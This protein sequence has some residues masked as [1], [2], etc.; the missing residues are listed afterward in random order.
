MPHEDSVSRTPQEVVEAPLPTDSL[1]WLLRQRVTI[2]E[3]VTGYVDRPELVERAMPTRRRLTVLHASAGFGKTT[4]LAECCRRLRQDGVATAWLSLDEGDVPPVLDAYIALACIGAGLNLLDAPDPDKAPAGPEGRIGLV[5]R[6]IQAFGKP[7][8]MAFDELERLRHPGSVSLL[9]FLLERGPSNLHLAFAC[10]EIPDGLDVAGALLAGR[11]EALETEDLRFSRAE[12]AT[13]FDLRLSRQ[14]LAEEMERST[15]WPFALRIS[16]NRRERAA[17]EAGPGEGLV[18]NWM[19]SRLLSDLGRD[20]REFVLDLGLFGWI[21][22]ALL[23]E[24]LPG[25]DATRRLESLGVLDGLLEPVGGGAT[26]TWRLH[27]LVREHCAARR[28]REDPER[29]SAIHRRIALALAGR[30]ETVLAMRHANDGGDPSLAGE[31]LERAGGVRVWIRQGVVQFQEAN[32]LLTREAVS[33]RPR[34]RRARCAALTLSGRHHEA[35]ALYRESPRPV[36]QA[37]AGDADLEC[38]L[39]DCIVRGA[40]SL[41]GGERIGSDRIRDLFGEMAGLA[42]LPSL[43]AFTRGYF[44]YALCILHSLKAEFDQ[45]LQRLSAARELL[46][47]THYLPLYGELLQGQMEFDSGRAAEAEAHYGRARRIARKYFLLDPVAVRST[48]ITRRELAL[49]C[50]RMATAS[51]P[52]DG[53]GALMNHAVPYSHFA[54]GISLLLDTYVLAGRNDRALAA[55]DE[56]LARARSAGLNGCTS[57]AAALRISVLVIDGRVADAKRAWRQGSLPEDPADCVDLS[58]QTRREMEAVSEA[59]VRLLTADGRLGEARVLLGKMRAVAVER[60]LR[61]FQMR[62]AALAVVLERHAGDSDASLRHLTEYL[63]MFGES[64]YTWPLVRER[65]T[66]AAVLR[67]FLALQ[68]HSPHRRGARSLLAAMRRVGG[69]VGVLLSERERE[70]LERIEGRRDKEI[71]AS[72]GLSAHGVR[73]HLRKLF[74][75]LGVTTRADAVRRARELG[76]IADDA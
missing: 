63:E 8:V 27:P 55:A 59:R 21:D 73:F 70:V 29:F 45:A 14:A 25:G 30:G 46:G 23:G 47:G 40:M 31:I 56:L 26:R 13:L 51:Q 24:V 43:D 64:P 12:V 3:R 50:G 75:R 66:C 20:D 53:P 57:L 60:R 38:Y 28:F 49:E 48:E 37:H 18:R 36:G 22:E 44:E 54:S 76:L 62:V 32:R 52:P 11:G 6:E 72:L 33:A 41:Y 9:A 58:A 39:E 65:A 67:R 74:R 34:L 16:R 69:E 17:R 2:P 35:R 42:R 61:R 15:G 68:P 19:E 10:R 4:L 71:A 7:F 1:S 5:M